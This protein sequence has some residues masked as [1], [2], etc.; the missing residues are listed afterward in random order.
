MDFNGTN[1]YFSEASTLLTNEP[2]DM[3]IFAKSNDAA[4]VQTLISLGNNGASGLYRLALQGNLGGDPVRVLKQSDAGAAGAADSSAGYSTGVWAKAWASFIS[5][6]SR[7]AGIDGGNKGTDA[8][9]V[10]DPTPDF[11]SIGATR[12]NAISAYANASLAHGYVFDVNL[13]DDQFAALSLGISALCNIPIA[14]IRG[15]YPLIMDGRNSVAN[16][17]PDLVATN[18]PTQGDMPPVFLP[19]I[20]GRISI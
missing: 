19:S 12:V 9:N 4:A 3:F 7:A 6:T 15:W 10:A 8:T 2:I 17:Y 18:S 20:G 16:G 13:T 5:N 11:I 1:Q 14:N